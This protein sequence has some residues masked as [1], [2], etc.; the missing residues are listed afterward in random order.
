MSF[1]ENTFLRLMRCF[2][3]MIIDEEFTDPESLS[4]TPIEVSVPRVVVYLKPPG[5]VETQTSDDDDW[6]ITN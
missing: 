1:R 2:Q 6:I 5:I 3:C 4:E